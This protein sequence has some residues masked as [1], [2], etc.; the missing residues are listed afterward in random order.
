MDRDHDDPSAPSRLLERARGGDASAFGEIVAAHRLAVY[1]TA[2]RILGSHDAADEAAQETFVRAWRGLAGF[3]G[4]SA[5][6]TWLI[7]IAINV[8]RSAAA[9]SAGT[10]GL[11][12]VPEIEGGGDSPS[13]VLLRDESR[14]RVRRAV[15]TL[16]P[17]QR[18]VVALKAFSDMT[19]EE[20]AAS[21]GL[22]VGAVKAHFHQAVANLRRRL[23][24]G[25]GGA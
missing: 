8:C 24:V 12:G 17:R 4:G 3:R 9:A 18:E 20:V 6:R 13:A 2:F 22:S 15:R 7:R 11:D 16:P 1:R 14:A 25:D 21:M 10:A 19:Y 23:T 5:L